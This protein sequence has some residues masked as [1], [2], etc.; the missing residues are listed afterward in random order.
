MS[1]VIISDSTCSLSNEEIKECGVK[2]INLSFIMDG[3][4]HYS[5]SLKDIKLFYEKLRKKENASTSCINSQMFYET[6][7]EELEKGNDIL[8][9]C[10]SS[11]LSATYAN[12]VAAKDE[13]LKKYPDRKIICVDTLIASYGGGML[14]YNAGLLHKQNKTI[15]EV[16]AY[17][18]YYKHKATALFTV[19]DL[20]F[21]YR[22]GRVKQTS[23]LLAKAINI[24]PLLHVDEEG[25]LIAYGKTLGRKKSLISLVDKLCETIEDPLNQEVYISHGDCLDDVNFVINLINKRIKVKGIKV[26]Y[27]D[28]VI[29]VHSGPNTL[30]LFYFSKIRV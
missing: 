5:D 13:A 22:G 19:D 2:V 25:R 9:V 14:I 24:K 21:L 16:A 26:S 4:E 18:E 11:A 17:L 28:P 7:V 1:Y 30:A 23:Y 12:S 20:F 6:F 3:K 27:I 8:C 15:D 10:F 29:G